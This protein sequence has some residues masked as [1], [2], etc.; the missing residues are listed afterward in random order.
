MHHGQVVRVKGEYVSR[1]LG[2]ATLCQSVTIIS[3]IIILKPS[4]S[5]Q[6]PVQS[7]PTLF[8]HA[9]GCLMD[10]DNGYKIVQKSAELKTYSGRR[11][12]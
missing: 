12:R 7:V 8:I 2:L 11:E 1:V 6:S 3:T 5:L 10:S 4:L 9:Q